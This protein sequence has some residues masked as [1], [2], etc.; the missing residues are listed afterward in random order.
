V[1]LEEMER[2]WSFADLADCHEALDIKAEIEDHIVEKAKQ[3]G[4]K[5]GR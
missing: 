1:T 4:A 5:G 3:E 2:H